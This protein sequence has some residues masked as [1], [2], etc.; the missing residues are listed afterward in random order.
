MTPGEQYRFGPF[1]VDVAERELRRNDEVVP[2][3][4]KTFDLLLILLRGAGRTLTK[5]ELMES[6]WPTRAVEESNLSQTIFLL[7]KAL[8]ENSEGVEYIFT[9][10]RRGYKFVGSV[11]RHELGDKDSDVNEVWGD[12]TRQQGA[13]SSTV[14]HRGHWRWL[15]VAAFVLMLASV[16]GFFWL[17]TRPKPMTDRDVLVL[18]DFSNSTGESVFDGILRE[19]LAFQLEQSPFLKVVDDAVM[20]QD[21]QRMRRSPEEPFSNDLAFDICVREGDKAML[22][23]SI[24]RLDKRYVIGLKTTDCQ[25]GATLAREQ[26]EAADREHVLQALAKAAQGMRAK[27]GESLSS[28]QSVSP[29]PGMQL[30]ATT[31]SLEALQD[32]YAGARFY[33]EGRLA[34]AVP[35]LQRATELDPN[36][37]F[38]WFWLAKVY[39][40]AG[41]RGRSE[42]YF[43][44]AWALRDRVSTYERLWIT[45]QRDGQ[46][47]GQYIQNL[48]TWERTYPRDIYPTHMLGLLYRTTGEF[49]KALAMFQAEHRA[50]AYPNALNVSGLITMHRQ[51][52]QFDKA[53]AVAEE[54]AAQGNDFPML[55]WHLLATAYA[56]ADREAALKQIKWFAGKPDEYRCV[57]LQSTEARIRGELRKSRE[58]LQQAANLARLRN[59]PEVA[60]ALL[61]PDAAG[62]AL[63]GNCR[64]AWMPGAVSGSRFEDHTDYP[65]QILVTRCSRSAER[66][67]WWRE[68]K[69]LISGGSAAFI[70]TRPKYRS[71]ELRCN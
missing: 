67:R 53:K 49:E 11:N 13:M 46:T 2:L 36:L 33:G 37:A 32:F 30:N 45:S 39:Y 51:L 71:L 20:R 61:K 48:K 8:A 9:V 38:A 58:L 70:G 29:P 22:G 52:D 34:E 66:R 62:D 64:A 44:R 69:R 54:M 56:E 47:T 15:Y 60:E 19:A 41:A 4:A 55:R 57:A 23:G 5:S 18:A 43:N 6:L 7:R 50:D 27:L 17:W 25:T 24:A 40:G 21:L 59:L 16:A 3:T 65:A 26:A 63:I 12:S 1:R 35:A 31:S 10:P 68:P 14:T 28:I 42:E